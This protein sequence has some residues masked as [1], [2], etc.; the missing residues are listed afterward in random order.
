MTIKAKAGVRRPSPFIDPSTQGLE[1]GEESS[2]SNH[3]AQE[4]GGGTAHLHLHGTDEATKQATH[5]SLA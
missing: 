3:R 5:G 2:A 4:H 1:N